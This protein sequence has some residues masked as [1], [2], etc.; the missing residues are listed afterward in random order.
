MC[1]CSVRFKYKKQNI[2]A[3]H[4]QRVLEVTQAEGGLLFTPRLYTAD[5]WSSLL[6]VEN[7]NQLAPYHTRTLVFMSHAVFAEHAGEKTCEWVSI[8]L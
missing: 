6:A 7:F 2:V 5:K 3:G 8:C 1:I 4:T